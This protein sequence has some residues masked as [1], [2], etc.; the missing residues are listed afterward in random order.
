MLK[1]YDH[2]INI[3]R[4]VEEKV[5]TGCSDGSVNIFDSNTMEMIG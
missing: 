2:T 1:Q 3:I 4:A 5:F